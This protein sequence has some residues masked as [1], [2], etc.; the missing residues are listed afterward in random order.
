MMLFIIL[1]SSPNGLGIDREG[2][3]M[4]NKVIVTLTAMAAVLTGCSAPLLSEGEVEAIKEVVESASETSVN[5]ESSESSL[6]S[7]ESSVTSSDEAI[8][9]IT[10]SDLY[11]TV[12]R[13]LVDNFG[14]SEDDLITFLDASGYDYETDFVDGFYHLYY[15]SEHNIRYKN[16]K[17]TK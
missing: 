15:I 16:T 3:S 12:Y 4:K 1:A 14:M 7:E 17:N 10:R 2:R 11:M 9:G 8:F 13:E 6:I 5:E